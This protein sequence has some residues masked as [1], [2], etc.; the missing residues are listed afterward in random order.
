M[1]GSQI[2]VPNSEAAGFSDVE[3]K[4]PFKT[5]SLLR[6]YSTTKPIVSVGAMRLYEQGKFKL[7]DSLH[8][9]RGEEAVC[10]CMR[11]LELDGDCR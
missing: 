8:A 2:N 4:A 10:C 5:D 1:G 3:G 7:D 9:R 6:I 11:G